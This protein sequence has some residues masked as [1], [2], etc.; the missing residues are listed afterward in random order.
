MHPVVLFFEYL[1]MIIDHH[2]L[3]ATS[4][5]R[6]GTDFGV[7]FNP[8]FLRESSAIN[9]FYEPP[10][11]V[12]GAVD[13]RSSAA[14]AQ[15]YKGLPGELIETSIEAAEYVKYIDNTWHGLKVGF[16]NEVGRLCKTVGVDSQ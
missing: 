7:C 14:L 10:K 2:I 6:C 8:E 13:Q 1:N 9:D 4:G 12:V 15:L 3:E 11:T 16:G 5:K